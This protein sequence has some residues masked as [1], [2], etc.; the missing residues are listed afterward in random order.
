MWPY[1]LMFLVPVWGVLQP[2][3]LPARQAY[4][5]WVAV[6]V[7]FA[8]MMGLRHEV[9]GDWFNYLP[10]FL[11]TQRQTLPEVLMRSDP[12]YYLLNWWVGR[13][14]ADIYLVNL[15][16]AM[17][18]MWGTVVFCRSQP[19]PWLALLAAVPYMLIVVGMGYTR[20]S[21]A[22]G[23]ALLGLTALGRGKPRS[24]IVW[25]AVAALFHK[26]AVLLMP[27]AALAATRNRI[28]TGVLVTIATALTYYLLLADRAEAL[29]VNYVEAQYQSQGGAIR[30]AMNAVPALLL[31]AFGR[32]LAPERQERR[33][34]LWMAAFALMCVPL[35]GLASTA[36]DRV[37][38]YL[39]PLQLFVFSRLPRLTGSTRARTLLVLA[40]AAYY[41]AV[42]F[43]WL[44][45]ASHAQYWLPYQWMAP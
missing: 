37:A 20:Q 43:V 4:W 8:A 42:L 24:F 45:F 13:L 12:G 38:L 14:G 25:I 7:L 21:V 41:A 35:V 18:L 28:L 44:H 39:I 34:W 36:V 11:D 31:I 30:V 6:G 22:L 27:I 15:L 33:L 16:C 29:W 9:G 32:R 19:Q 10:H 3:R 2:R 26:S 17:V 5:V 40:I 23:F 1:W